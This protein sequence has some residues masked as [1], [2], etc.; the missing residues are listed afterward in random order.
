MV[1]VPIRAIIAH[2]S[3]LK[4]LVKYDDC[5][6]PHMVTTMRQVYISVSGNGLDYERFQAT[7]GTHFGGDVFWTKKLVDA[8]AVPNEKYWRSVDYSFDEPGFLSLLKRFNSSIEG[9]A[10]GNAKV[11]FVLYGRC[12]GSAE[13]AGKGV[14]LSSETIRALADIKASFDYDLHCDCFASNAQG[15]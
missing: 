9:V 8:K 3:G 5:D 2:S 11:S 7:V 10:L 14:Y 12:N 6:G 15:Q 4:V 1:T 13:F